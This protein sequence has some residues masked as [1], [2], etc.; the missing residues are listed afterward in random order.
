MAKAHAYKKSILVH[1]AVYEKQEVLM[2]PAQYRTTSVKVKDA[3]YVMREYVRLTLNWE[4]A[5]TLRAVLA[6]VGGSPEHSRRGYARGITEALA[7]A[8]VEYKIGDGFDIIINGSLIF[9]EQHGLD[10]EGPSRDEDE[11]EG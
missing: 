5:E 8:G 2:Q 6:R 9:R 4:E 10:I 7:K 3:A 11:E 1:R